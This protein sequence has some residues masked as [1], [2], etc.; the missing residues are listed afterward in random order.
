MVEP[1][2][3]E[4]YAC[5]IGS[6]P[7]LRGKNDLVDDFHRHASGALAS[8]PGAFAWCRQSLLMTKVE[9]LQKRLI[10]QPTISNTNKVN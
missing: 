6:F 7:N 8:L 9:H 5:Q 3:F 2:R 1:T 10:N 4:K